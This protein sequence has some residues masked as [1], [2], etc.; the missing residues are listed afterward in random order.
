MSVYLTPRELTVVC[1]R[2]N[3]MFVYLAEQR[4]ICISKECVILCVGG[5]M[6]TIIKR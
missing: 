1:S 4:G 6:K 2:G 3:G 5:V